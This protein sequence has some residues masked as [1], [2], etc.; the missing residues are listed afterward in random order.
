M[1]VRCTASRVRLAQAGRVAAARLAVRRY[2]CGVLIF[3]LAIRAAA[4]PALSASFEGPD[5][6]VN[7]G[8]TRLRLPDVADPHAFFTIVHAVSRRGA[9][10][11]L[12]IGSS[13]LTRGWPPKGGNCG[14]GVESFIRW[15]HVRDGRVIGTQEGRYESCRLN[16]DAWGIA[17][18]G[19]KLTWSSRGWKPS[20]DAVTEPAAHLL[21]WTYDPRHP[22]RGIVEETP[23]DWR[24]SSGQ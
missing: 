7:R 8:Q 15:L 12:V 23:T 9:D 10:L 17:W 22:E 5:L 19:G 21:R 18:Q 3:G 6:R 16:R 2:A 4:A 20:V 11:Y 24:P 13:E 14:C 1:S